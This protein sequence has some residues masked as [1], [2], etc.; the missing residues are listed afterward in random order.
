M[1]GPHDRCYWVGI[2]LITTAMPTLRINI[3][4]AVVTSSCQSTIAW[5]LVMAT[6]FIDHQMPVCKALLNIWTSKQ[7]LSICSDCLKSIQSALEFMADPTGDIL[8]HSH[9]REI[10]SC[11]RRGCLSY[12]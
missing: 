5:E 10:H 12:R 2:I 6:T 3:S 9:S 4:Q 7:A 8:R 1:A 11:L